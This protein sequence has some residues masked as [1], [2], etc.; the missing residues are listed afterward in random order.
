MKYLRR[1]IRQILLT[2]GMYTPSLLK[3]KNIHIVI[4]VSG[5]QIWI[6]AQKIP[7][8]GDL[9]PRF[10]N[11]GQLSIRWQEGNHWGEGNCDGAWSVEDAGVV[12]AVSGLGPLL[13]DLAMEFAGKDGIMSDRHITSEPAR[14]VWYHYLEARN[15][16]EEVLL[17]YRDEPW[18]T[19]KDPSDDCS[20]RQYDGSKSSKKI[21]KVTYAN[22]FAT[23]K[24]R[25]KPLHTK[26]IK[27]LYDM[28]L[29]TIKIIGFGDEAHA[30]RIRAMGIEI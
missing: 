21:D 30:D 12:E 27:S 5:S 1:Y 13:Y 16:V 2:E 25:K 14:K 29:L 15:D 7:V 19:P 6:Q 24:F 10:G 11:V 23:N 28:G 4:E 22:H 9:N 26:T 3:E 18:I 17:D 20:Q 8:S